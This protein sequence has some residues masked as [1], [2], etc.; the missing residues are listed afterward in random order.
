MIPPHLYA[1]MPPPSNSGTHS[2]EYVDLLKK[3]FDFMSKEVRDVRSEQMSQNHVLQ[4]TLTKFL[5]I[6]AQPNLAT[7]NI[8]PIPNQMQK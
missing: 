4:E 1:M 3:M 7:Q 8:A 6:S 2:A 5:T